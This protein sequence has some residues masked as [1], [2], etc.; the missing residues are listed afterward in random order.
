MINHHLRLKTTIW[1]N[2]AFFSRH[3]KQIQAV[4]LHLKDE[5][6]QWFTEQCPISRGPKEGNDIRTFVS[7]R[8][9]NESKGVHP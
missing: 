3:L 1:D 6:K 9:M 7:R 4:E 2:I 8:F 5:K